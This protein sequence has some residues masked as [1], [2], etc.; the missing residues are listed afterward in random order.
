MAEPMVIDS[1]VAAKWFLED[2]SDTDLAENLLLA[3][4]A[5]DIEGYIPRVALYEV[6]HLLTKACLRPSKTQPGYR[7]TTDRAARCIREFL[8]LPLQKPDVTDHECLAAFEMATKYSK[9][10]A[11]MAFLWR[12]M[13]L[14]CQWCTADEKVL[15]ACGPGFPIQHVLLLSVTR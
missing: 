14:D 8:D 9:G 10:H 5:G 6:C 3:I 13:Q 4:L 15:E 2:E 1:S 7:I 12:A 11:D